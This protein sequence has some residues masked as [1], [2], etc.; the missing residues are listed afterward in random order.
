MTAE[1]Q[2]NAAKKQQNWRGW[3]NEQ[4]GLHRQQ[5][6]CTELHSFGA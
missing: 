2:A 5:Q 4:V 3:Y 6:A 1:A